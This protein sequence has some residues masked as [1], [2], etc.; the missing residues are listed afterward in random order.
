MLSP[1]KLKEVAKRQ[2]V[3][4]EA[5]ARGLVRGGLDMKEAT[6]R[7]KNWQRGLMRPL[8]HAEDVRRLAETL[9]VETNEIAAWRS[10]YMYAPQSCRKVRLVTQLILGREVQDAMDLLKFTRKR[11]ATMVDQTLKAAVADADE[12]QADVENLYVSEARVD[13]AGIRLGTKRWIPKDRGRAHPIHKRACHIHITV[14]QKELG[15]AKS[16]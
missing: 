5:L 1:A 6:S 10:S 16:H 9:S 3:T 8:P 7:V 14:T 12:Q 4:T 11:A 13:D 2:G 15:S